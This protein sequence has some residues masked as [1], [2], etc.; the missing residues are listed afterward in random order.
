MNDF[1]LE[2]I[3]EVHILL[4][5]LL[6]EFKKVCV[7][8]NIW[9]SLAYG[10]VL[11]AVRHDGF[12]PWD[13]DADVFLCLPDKEAFRAAFAKTD[14]GN[15]ILKNCDTSPRC[16]QCHDSLVYKDKSTTI[17][18]D[19]Y[20]LV[21]APS[22]I[23]KREIFTFCSYYLDRIIR[24]K[25]VDIRKCLPQN[26]PLV[27]ASKVITHLIPDKILRKNIHRRETKV[28]FE[29]AEYL[30]DLGCD[31]MSSGCIPKAVILNVTEHL[32]E[33]EKFNI[34]S[35]YD[36]YLRRTYGNDYMIPKRY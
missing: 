20:L 16:M 17:H 4:L 18:L 11:G 26:R 27:F 1:A 23:K 3:E 35:N 31:N 12:I 34:P 5:P 32:F 6:K 7:E 25:Y 22:S 24:S 15:I 29:Q 13:A 21:G 14:H 19:I 36:E 33:G 30:T 9:Y 2:G 28:S 8:N 10:S